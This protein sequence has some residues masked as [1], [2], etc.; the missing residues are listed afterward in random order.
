M[1]WIEIPGGS[2]V[3]GARGDRAGE[4]LAWIEARFEGSAAPDDCGRI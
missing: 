1:R 4:T 2:H 3:D